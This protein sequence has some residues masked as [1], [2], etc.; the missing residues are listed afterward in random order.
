MIKLALQQTFSLS[1]PAK[2]FSENFSLP[3][4]SSSSTFASAD[5]NGWRWRDRGGEVRW[6][7]QLGGFRLPSII[8]AFHRI[9]A[10][11]SGKVSPIRCLDSSGCMSDFIFII[12]S[13][14]HSLAADLSIKRNLGNIRRPTR[15][16]HQMILYSAYGGEAVSW[17]GRMSFLMRFRGARYE[18]R[19]F[20]CLESIKIFPAAMTHAR[21]LFKLDPARRDAARR[22]RRCQI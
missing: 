14:Q 10:P 8:T 1:C 7:L 3:F 12:I 18:A 11:M 21:A 2:L 20:L 19:I 17:L 22:R 5:V 13:L 4:S 9:Y 16:H 15:S 6:M